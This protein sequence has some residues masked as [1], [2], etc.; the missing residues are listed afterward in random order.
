MAISDRS[1]GCAP[2]LANARSLLVRKG[3]RERVGEPA[4]TIEHLAGIV[5]AVL[6]GGFGGERLGLSTVKPGPP[7]SARLR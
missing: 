1:G 6:D 3:R 7:G 2:P 5:R 4:G